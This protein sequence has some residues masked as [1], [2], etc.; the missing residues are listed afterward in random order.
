M[1]LTRTMQLRTCS[2]EH[3]LHLVH[4]VEAMRIRRLFE[5]GDLTQQPVEVEGIADP[6]TEEGGATAPREH[7]NASKRQGKKKHKG[8]GKR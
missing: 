8:K 2:S 4:S 3:E 7:V 6:V 5:R 1:S